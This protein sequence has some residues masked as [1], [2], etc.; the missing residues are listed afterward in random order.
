MPSVVDFEQWP[1][2]RIEWPMVTTNE[3]LADLEAG[4]LRAVARREKFGQLTLGPRDMHVPNATQRAT[5]A[6]IQRDMR[7]ALETYC[8]ADAMVLPSALARGTLTVISWLAPS[9][10]PQAVFE[11]ERSAT[12]WIEERFAAAGMSLPRREASARRP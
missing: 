6:R 12:V 11:D 1:L 7:A 3:F 8:I 5:I 9:P 10:H 4:F 2:I